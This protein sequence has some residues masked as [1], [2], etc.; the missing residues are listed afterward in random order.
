MKILI[1]GG[2]G[3]I[4]TNLIDCFLKKQFKILNLDINPP[5]NH[6]HMNLWKQLNICDYKFLSK[7][8]IDFNPNF[9][10]HLAAKTDL[11]GKSLTDYDAN[12]KGVENIME[13][14]KD[15]PALKRVIIASSMLVCKIGY[16]PKSFE[17]YKPD[18][19][20]GE[21]KV[22]TEKIVK[23]YKI[24]WVIVRPTSI[25]GPWF[26]APYKNFFELVLKGYY[27]NIPKSKSATKTFGYV[28]NTCDQIATLLLTNNKV[29]SKN[30]FYLG[31]LEPINIHEWA[32]MI[33]NISGK[34]RL[35]TFPLFVLKYGSYF[36][37]LIKDC[38]KINTPL[39]KFRYRNMTT[40]NIIPE[41]D[42]LGEI[43]FQRTQKIEKN[44][45]ETI[46]WIHSNKS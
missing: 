5:R 31:D 46:H 36:G 9:I 28:K 17:D 35:I 18:T 1:T 37:Q 44:I 42:K 3:F 16:K 43:G 21:S 27:F 8:V 41:M 25:W 22:L 33:R 4:G 10:V 12:V 30:Y 24:D 23:K 6:I 45:N 2:S 7:A 39:N 40:D 38:F 20:Y 26:G 32:N 14:S 13:I 29:I 15:I 19:I 34:N 11:N